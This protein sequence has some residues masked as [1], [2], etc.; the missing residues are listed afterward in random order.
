M[1]SFHILLQYKKLLFGEFN[2]IKIE[3]NDT[4]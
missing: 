4:I 2:F 1:Y 3:S